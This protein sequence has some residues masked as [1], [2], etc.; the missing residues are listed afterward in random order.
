MRFR[1]VDSL[2]FPEPGEVYTDK[3]RFYTTPDGTFPSVTTI[4]SNYGDNSWLQ[5][6]RDRVGEREADKISRQARVRGTAVHTIAE[7]YIRG[8]DYRKGQMPNNI[9]SFNSIKGFIDENLGLVAGLE[10]PLW[11]KRLKVAGRSDCIGKWKGIW[12][13][14]DFK[15]SR[16]EKNR[17][18]IHGYFLQESAYAQMFEELTGKKVP[19]LVTLMMVDDG[20]SQMFVEKT[21]DWAE[22]FVK[23]RNI[24][25]DLN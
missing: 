15:T 5:E 13:V 7:K 21:D 19:Q 1:I 11:S 25:G 8:E 4:L 9:I 3:G 20:Q 24:V 2:E 6:W 10:I 23:L 22:E 17:D 14:I 12:S 18:D 16:R